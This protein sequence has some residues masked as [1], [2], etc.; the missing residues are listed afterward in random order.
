MKNYPVIW[1]AYCLK[2]MKN[3][4]KPG[5]QVHLKAQLQSD[6]ESAR[7]GGQCQA[8]QASED[9]HQRAVRSLQQGGRRGA[10]YF[11]LDLRADGFRQAL[12]HSG[13]EIWSSS[14]LIARGLLHESGD[15][16]HMWPQALTLDTQI[17]INLYCNEHVKYI[18]GTC[19]S[20]PEGSTT[21]Q[22]VAFATL[23]VW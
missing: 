7:A 6:M 16:Q 4:C 21:L 20:L 2:K 15:G 8:V 13:A 12:E 18:D 11:S 14:R 17:L 5:D 9:D 22:V 1:L 23:A 3:M 19:C 10:F